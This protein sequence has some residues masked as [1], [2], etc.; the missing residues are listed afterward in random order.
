MVTFKAF[1]YILHWYTNTAK[2][3]KMEKRDFNKEKLTWTKN[4]RFKV[5]LD[6]YYLWKKCICNEIL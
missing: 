4:N 1:E 5:S 3:L 6:S 2:L